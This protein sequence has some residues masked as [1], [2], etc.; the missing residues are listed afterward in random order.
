MLMLKIKK[1]KKYIILIYFYFK[2][3]LKN[4]LTKHAM[5]ELFSRFI[6]Y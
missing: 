1:I 3:I 4:Y 5:Y 2:N 6:V